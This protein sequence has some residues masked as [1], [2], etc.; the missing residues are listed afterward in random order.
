MTSDDREFTDKG[1]ILGVNPRGPV[2]RS[3]PVLRVDGA[4][5]KARAIVFGYACHG[6]TNPPSPHA[7]PISSICRCMATPG[8]GHGDVRFPNSGPKIAVEAL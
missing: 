7:A 6:T 4:D 5:G 8:S 2:D 1:V 3:V